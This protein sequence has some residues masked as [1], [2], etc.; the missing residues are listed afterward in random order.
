[1]KEIPIPVRKALNHI[2]KYYPDVCMVVFG[3]DSRWH[4]MTNTFD[5]PKFGK[6][7][8]VSIL[9]AAA[10]CLIDFPSVFEL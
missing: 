2:R 9:E 3:S 7:I 6:E 10:D 4:Y 8:D 5:A 1:M